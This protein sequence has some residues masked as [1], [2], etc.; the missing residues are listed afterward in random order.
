MKSLSINSTF[1][2]VYLRR[3]PEWKCGMLL[4]WVGLGDGCHVIDNDQQWRW[5]L[6]ENRNPRFPQVIDVIVPRYEILASLSPFSPADI[7]PIQWKRAILKAF[8]LKLG[9]SYTTISRQWH[10]Y[11]RGYH[12]ALPYPYPWGYLPAYP[13][14]SMGGL[15]GFVRVRVPVRDL[16]TNTSVLTFVKLYNVNYVHAY[17]CT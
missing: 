4:G 16:S 3:W 11:S 13:R 14:V 5:S 15:P 7:P 10:G 8:T 2:G 9:L 12:W 17:F 6:A 1:L